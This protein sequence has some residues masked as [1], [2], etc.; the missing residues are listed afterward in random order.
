M[1]LEKRRFRDL[2]AADRLG[3]TYKAG[4][5]TLGGEPT[6]WIAYEWLWGAGYLTL[7]GE[8]LVLTERGEKAVSEPEEREWLLTITGRVPKT[9]NPRRRSATQVDVWAYE[10]VL[11]R[12]QES[13]TGDDELFLEDVAR[14]ASVRRFVDDDRIWVRH[15]GRT[16]NVGTGLEFTGDESSL[17]RWGPMSRADS[18]LNPIRSEQVADHYH[19]LPMFQRHA[20]RKLVVADAT[21]ESLVDA[22]RQVAP[23]SGKV[24]VKATRAKY[25]LERLDVTEG[26][27]RA[28]F[29]SD[30]LTLA[31]MHLDGDRDAFLVQ[32]HIDMTFERRYFVV[33]HLTVTSAGAVEESTPYDRVVSHSDPRTR[34]RRGVNDLDIIWASEQTTVLS[35]FARQVAHEVK[36][37]PWRKDLTEY[38]LDVALDSDGNPLIV[39]FNGIR[40]SG[41]YAADYDRVIRVLTERRDVWGHAPHARPRETA[42]V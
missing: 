15:G 37:S 23:A 31:L 1:S 34:R 10:R 14:L 27:E 30:A 42:G 22:I 21:I 32:E 12:P 18:A 16:F 33:D 5:Y 11:G 4:K 9:S 35:D 26:I 2:Q 20:G 25:A 6:H 40:N 29:D 8:D 38:V 36:A 39:E 19:Q 7:N 41:L 28:L 13:D 3:A 24:I 17:F